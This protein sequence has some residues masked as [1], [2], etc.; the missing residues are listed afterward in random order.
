MGK[1]NF[2]LCWW[3]PNDLDLHVTC[4]CGTNIYFGFKTCPTCKGYLDRDARN[5]AQPIEHIFFNTPRAGTY[6]YKVRFYGRG[7]YQQ[8]QG[9]A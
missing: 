9:G 8:K 4:P 7:S 1:F 6:K 5:E 3:D 2:S